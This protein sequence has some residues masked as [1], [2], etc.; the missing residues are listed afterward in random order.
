MRI[1]KSLFLFASLTLGEQALAQ[2]AAQLEALEYGK[3]AGSDNV[4]SVF[5][6]I[7]NEQGAGVIRNF[8][9]TPPAQSS[10]WGGDHTGFSGLNVGG[11]AKITECQTG[12]GSASAEDTQH[13]EAVKSII[14]THTD[15]PTGLVSASDELLIK[16]KAITAN[17][18]AIAGAIDGAYSDCSTTTESQGPSFSL[19]TCEEWSISGTETCSL[20][21]VVD[22][23][24][25]YLYRCKESLSLVKATT[26]S[27]GRVVEVDTEHSY[28]CTV[29]KPLETNKCRRGHAAQVGIEVKTSSYSVDHGTAVPNWTSR[30]FT[31]TMSLSGDPDSFRLIAYQV[32]NYGQL[33]INGHLVYQNTLAGAGW[34]TDIRNSGVVRSYEYKLRVGTTNYSLWDD[35][36]NSGCRGLHPNLD[37]TSYLVDAR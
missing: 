23:D 7:S 2:S 29:T 30:T 15:K 36:C 27:Y 16:G 5:D 3:S 9:T 19:Q 32:D 20:D 33:W 34:P 24:A 14:K 26:C 11:T 18:A 8:S 13:C 22:I 10:Y 6:G 4:Q 21:Q 1:A 12:P 31:T 25:N 37:I 35:D 28:Q 17:P